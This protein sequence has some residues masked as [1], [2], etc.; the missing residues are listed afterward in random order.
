MV[1]GAAVGQVM[2]TGLL[3]DEINDGHVLRLYRWRELRELLERHP[4]RIDTAS[5]A[6]FIVLGNE[7]AFEEDARWL[8]EE[9]A[10]CREP[11][12][13]DG[14]THIVAVVQRT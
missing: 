14:G 8:E 11:G 7:E 3:T 5:A 4:C 9:I 1:G 2:A 13:L 12:A 6:N 10:A